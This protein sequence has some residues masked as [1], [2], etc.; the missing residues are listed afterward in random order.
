MKKI[1]L[2]FALLSAFVAVNAQNSIIN[3]SFENW[4]TSSIL[5]QE[6]PNDWTAALVGN[7]TQ[8]VFGYQVPIPVN[9]YFGS[10]T[11]ESHSG[12]YALKLQANTVGISG[13]DYSFMMPGLLQYGHA[14]GF[15]IPLS[16]ILD[17][18]NMISNQDTSGMSDIDWT[19]FT[20]LMNILSPGL[21][22]TSTPTHLNLWVKY[23]PEGD[24]SLWLIAYTK[25][26]GIPVSYAQLETGATMT[27]YTQLTATFENPNTACDSLCI[28]L[29]SGGFGTDA[30]TVLYIDDVSI[31]YEDG[32]EVFN[33]PQLT[34]Y[35]NPATDLLTIDTK[36]NEVYDYQLTDLAGKM[37]IAS[38]SEQG[39]TTL[40]VH[41][42]TPGL[43][44]LRVSQNN[45]QVIRKVIV[46]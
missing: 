46:R 36:S 4:A 41:N 31:D 2:I 24:D 6:Q 7:V 20:S 3:G 45:H 35:P 29:L 17:I 33:Q 28:I 38:S 11:T 13:T 5:A 19:S 32:I 12:N 14:E 23:L 43:Y 26:N 9:T 30:N 39:V 25:S 42:L 16:S 10:K 40:S 8:E 15:S 21:P 34:I 37:I 27:D 18:V 22:C 44:L 1:T